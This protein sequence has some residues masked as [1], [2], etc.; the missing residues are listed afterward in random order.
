M[1]NPNEHLTF[2]VNGV[3][4]ALP[5]SLSE[6]RGSFGELLHAVREQFD[7]RES[8][9]SSIRVDGRELTENEEMAFALLPLSEVRSLE[10]ATAHP[11]E[12]AEETLQ[13]LL[14]FTD[15]LTRLSRD[16]GQAFLAQGHPS[17]ELAKLMDGIEM[18][19][20]ALNNVRQI[21]RVGMA[22]S[23]DLLEADLTSIMKDMLDTYQ[24]GQI[25]Y[26]AELLCQHLPAN[27]EDWKNDGLPSL[28][29]SR[30]S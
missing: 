11:R 16:C 29:R 9:I 1:T 23:I 25:G 24:Q 12:I 26:V 10:I 2:K 19:L 7:S 14:V 21:L 22:N 20:E 17:R 6:E 3:D 15:H 13:N 27:L 28:I 18:F 4:Q 8:C 5:D 30:D